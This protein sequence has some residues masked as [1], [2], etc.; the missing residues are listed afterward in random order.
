V[1][2]GVLW[3]VVSALAAWFRGRRPQ[4]RPG[5][6]CLTATAIIAA[7]GQFRALLLSA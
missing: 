4:G 2:A 1:W 3:L 6:V 5:L 7:G